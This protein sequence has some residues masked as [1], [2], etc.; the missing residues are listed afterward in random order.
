M[1][2]LSSSNEFSS[3][4]IYF[5]PISTTSTC[6]LLGGKVIVARL[7]SLVAELND[8]T[9]RWFRDTNRYTIKA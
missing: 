8:G 7:Y 2:S 6:L 5:V 1:L 9:F 3:R 4:P